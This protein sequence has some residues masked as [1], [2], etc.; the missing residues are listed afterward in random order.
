MTTPQIARNFLHDVPPIYWL[1]IAIP[2]VIVGPLAEE[3]F[4]RG[5]AWDRLSSVMPSW[6]AGTISAALFLGPHI[7]NGLVAP[8]FVLPLTI[9][10]TVL[11]LR[12]VG[13]GVC[14]AAHV[15]YNGTIILGNFLQTYVGPLHTPS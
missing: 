4:F 14:V 9:I 6:K 15:I 5:N 13:L 10:V 1:T 8:L 12:R 11:R 7:F 2:Y 3:V